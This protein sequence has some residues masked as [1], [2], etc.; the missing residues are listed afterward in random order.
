[1]VSMGKYNA[2]TDVSGLRVGHYTQLEAACGVT[3]VICPAGAVAAVDVRGAAPGTRETDL[4]NPMNLVEKAQ[5]VVL[6]GGSVYGLAAA[7]GVVGWLAERGLGFALDKDHVAPIVPGAVL[8]DLGRGSSF[9][10]PISA[11]WGRWAC[12]AATEEKVAM[13]C[14]GAGTGAR[15]GAIKGGV[16]TASYVL[17]D[18]LTVAALAAVN[19]YGTGVDQR[20][21]RLW[22]AGL[23]IGGEFGAAGR[24]RVRPPVQQMGAAGCH[25]T[26]GIVATDAVLAKAQAQKVA[27]MAHDGLARDIR[28]CHTMFDGD[29]IFCLATGKR[30]LTQA[31]GLFADVGGQAINAIGQSAADCMARAIMHAILAASSSYGL[32]A[33]NDLE[34]R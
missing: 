3:V 12:E 26:L 33:F 9:I 20:T 6:A 7:D 14:V 11:A 10:P 1:M 16:G 30:P 24:L 17:D 28:P 31:R 22:E 4:L 19:S 15:S 32:C 18:G 23:E 2:L 34:T 13:G 8:Y 25:T 21:G 29:T 27:Q 5:A